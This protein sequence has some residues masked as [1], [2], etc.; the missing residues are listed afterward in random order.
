MLINSSSG[1]I[2]LQQAALLSP[3][4]GEPAIPPVRDKILQ[5]SQVVS[6]G[7]YRIREEQI[8]RE[9]TGVTRLV[10]RARGADG[11]TPVWIARTRGVG[12]GEGSSGVTFD[13][14]LPV[15]RP[16]GSTA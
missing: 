2:A 12:T 7:P 13:Q 5:P 1:E 16:P 8:P 14:A 9:G 6:R 11:T 3:S 15:D 10:R 4:G